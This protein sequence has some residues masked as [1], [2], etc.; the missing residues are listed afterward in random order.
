MNL[1]TP[2]NCTV[3]DFGW[4]NPETHPTRIRYGPH[5]TVNGLKSDT[6]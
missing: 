6:M 4:D 3:D 5:T 1:Q 2:Y